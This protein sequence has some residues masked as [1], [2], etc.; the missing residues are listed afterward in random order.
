MYRYRTNPDSLTVL[1]MGSNSPDNPPPDT[2]RMSD[3]PAYD[4]ASSCGDN[5]V[6]CMPVPIDQ[7]RPT[8]PSPLDDELYETDNDGENK[9]GGR[10]T[11][12]LYPKSPPAEAEPTWA[13]DGAVAPLATSSSIN[14]GVTPSPGMPSP[15]KMAPSLAQAVEVSSGTEHRSAK[16]MD[17]YM[18]SSPRE[19]IVVA[20][21][22]T[23]F[24]GARDVYPA[25]ISGGAVRSPKSLFWGSFFGGAEREQSVATWQH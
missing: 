21:R 5:S 1:S 10:S 18:L 4:V 15:E 17:P 6:I 11:P 7:P 25:E 12:T 20:W 24:V 19:P 23:A 13:G 9:A 14:D 8:Q 16:R 22:C 3:R 2:R